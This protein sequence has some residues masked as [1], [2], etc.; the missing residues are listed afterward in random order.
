MGAEAT[1][2]PTLETLFGLASALVL[3]GWA[4][5]L[6]A[7]WA[8]R[9]AQWVAGLAIPLVLSIGYASLALSSLVPAL[10]GGPGEMGKSQGGFG[11][12]AGVMALFER[13]EAVLAGWVHYLAFDLLIGALI[14]RRARACG[15]PHAL[16]LVCLPLTFLAGP[17]GWLLFQAIRGARAATG[18]RRDARGAP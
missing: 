14:V 10:A 16:V 9:P 13:P 17:A 5:L 6:I 3:P 8:P 4:M 2:D 11:S 18:L 12:L 1:V 7:P 15:V